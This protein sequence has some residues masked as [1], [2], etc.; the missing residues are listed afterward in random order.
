MIKALINGIIKLLI[1]I[2]NI[3]LLPINTLIENVFP[4]MSNAITTFTNFI[5]NI[6][7]TNMVFFFQLLPPIFRT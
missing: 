3:V 5:N 1:M 2:L 6:L 4:S 7:G